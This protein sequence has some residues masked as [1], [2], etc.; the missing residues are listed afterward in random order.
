MKS[1][2]TLIELIIAFAVSTMITGALFLSF[3]QVQKSTKIIEKMLSIDSPIFTF[4]NQFEKDISG[5]FEPKFWFPKEE[6]K[7]EEKESPKKVEEDKNKKPALPT[8]KEE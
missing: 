8:K 1:G 2:F 4:S 6:E 3:S 7:K 5:A